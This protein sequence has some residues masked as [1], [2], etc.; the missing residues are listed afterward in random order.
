MASAKDSLSRGVYVGDS[1]YAASD[2]TGRL[3]ITT[4]N[5][6]P[7]DPRNIIVVEPDVWVEL[8]GYVKRELKH[9]PN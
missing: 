9:Y 6:Y 1:V 4:N 7:D 5:G 3:V 8:T 2:D